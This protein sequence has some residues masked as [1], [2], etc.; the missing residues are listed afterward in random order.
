MKN[1]RLNKAREA[2]ILMVITRIE[3][4]TTDEKVLRL[5]ASIKDAIIHG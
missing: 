2:Y 4:L 5:L 1:S 3:Y